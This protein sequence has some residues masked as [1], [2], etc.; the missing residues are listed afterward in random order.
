[1]LP[2]SQTGDLE[3]T[4][5]GLEGERSSWRLESAILIV[6]PDDRMQAHQ[7]PS[8]MELFMRYVRPPKGCAR[9]REVWY[10]VSP[11]VI[12]FQSQADP[13]DRQADRKQIYRER[14]W[15]QSTFT[16]DT[17]GEKCDTR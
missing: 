13:A 16:W 15:C 4:L 10:A 5:F 9:V 17:P 14:E 1:M 2:R 6:A 12:Q 3:E 11:G 8:S 7:L